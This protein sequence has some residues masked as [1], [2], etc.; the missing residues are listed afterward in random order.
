MSG[1]NCC[2]NN[3][4][5]LFPRQK[6]GFFGARRDVKFKRPG[7]KELDYIFAR[8]V[9]SPHLLDWDRDGHSD[10]VVGYVEVVPDGWDWKLFI[11]AG[12]LA[13]KTEL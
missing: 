1:S 7:E 6:D 4:V 11:G 3:L 8:G 12:P 10:L 13:G 5:H 2:R 9:T